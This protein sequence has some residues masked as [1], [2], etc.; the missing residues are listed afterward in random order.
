MQAA[1]SHS[2]RRR[3]CN[4]VMRKHTAPVAQ[5]AANSRRDDAVKLQADPDRSARSL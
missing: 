3:R 1:D 4:A 2:M 5:G